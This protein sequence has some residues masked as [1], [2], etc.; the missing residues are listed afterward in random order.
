MFQNIT[1][2]FKKIKIFH[3]ENMDAKNVKMTFL[4]NRLREDDRK[5]APER[6]CYLV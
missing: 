3:G 6:L 2:F 5:L 1:D 4:G